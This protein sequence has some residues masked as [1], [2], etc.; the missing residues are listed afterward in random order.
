MDKEQLISKLNWFY[1]FELNQVD[2]YTSQSKSTEDDYIALAFERIAYIEQQHVDNI[3]N[4][5]KKLGGKPTALGDV[6]APIIGKTLGKV[7]ALSGIGN[8]LKVNI[9]LEQKAM[10]DYKELIH[11][12]KGKY[13]N[14]VV[15]ILQSNLIDEDLHAAW[16]NNKLLEL[17][18]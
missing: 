1:S 9:L 16:F 13:D 12:V 5:I 15:K 14:E 11:S 6:V 18:K 8:L 2:L 7:L 10:K 17:K 4:K 3:G